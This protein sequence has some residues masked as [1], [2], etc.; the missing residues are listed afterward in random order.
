MLTTT[1][2][3]VL[4]SVASLL[5]SLYGGWGGTLLQA[6]DLALA[7]GTAA[8]LAYSRTVRRQ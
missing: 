8:G 6:G 5:A 4:G 7:V 1:A 2:L 3:M